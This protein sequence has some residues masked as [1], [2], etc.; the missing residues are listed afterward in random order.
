MKAFAWVVFVM[1]GMTATTWA[2]SVNRTLIGGY[3]VKGFDVVAYFS[4]GRPVKG[5]RSLSYSWAGAKWLFATAENRDRFVSDPGAYA[6][7]YGGFCAWAVSQG[8]TADID[9]QAW[10]IVAGKLYLNYNADVQAKWSTDVNGL[11]RKAD[12]NWPRLRER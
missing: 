11:I 3:A 5:E 4:E 10:K 9:P 12:E 8:Y 2:D 7:Q 1:L 6:P